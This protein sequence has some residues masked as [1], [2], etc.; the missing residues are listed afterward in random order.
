MISSPTPAA[1]AA[2]RTVRYMFQHVLLQ[3]KKEYDSCVVPITASHL[4]RAFTITTISPRPAPS[5]SSLAR[6]T[7]ADSTPSTSNTTTCF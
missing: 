3:R 1:V 4:A 6:V 5:A 7:N 2:T